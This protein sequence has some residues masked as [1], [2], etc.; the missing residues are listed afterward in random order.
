MNERR[1][2]Y[3]TMSPLARDI[4]AGEE[5]LCN[6]IF[7][8]AAYEHSV[9]YKSIFSGADV[10]DITKAEMV[11]KG[12]PFDEALDFEIEGNCNLKSFRI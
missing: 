6:C 12:V 9:L 2:P 3:L 8:K 7:L 4:I 10:G 5:I 11:L 1:P